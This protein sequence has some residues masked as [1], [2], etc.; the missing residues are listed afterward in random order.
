MKKK[1]NPIGAFSKAIGNPKKHFNPD[2]LRV[3]IIDEADSMMN[4]DASF[5][6]DFRAALMYVVRRIFYLIIIYYV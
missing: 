4:A 3:W 5:G 1:T 6:K 2:L